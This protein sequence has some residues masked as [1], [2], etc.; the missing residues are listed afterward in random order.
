MKKCILILIILTF[1]FTSNLGIIHGKDKTQLDLKAEK[2]VLIDEYSI[3]EF[4][5]LLEQCKSTS[6]ARGG[7]DNTI[8]KINE[9]DKNALKFQKL[10]N[11][12]LK[13]VGFNSTQIN[14]IRNYNFTNETRSRVASDINVKVYTSGHLYIPEKNQTELGLSVK[15][16][17]S[18][19]Q[20]IENNDSILMGVVGT[21]RRYFRS[22]YSQ[23]GRFLYVNSDGSG[24]E[25]DK[26][27]EDIK[28][29]GEGV[30]EVKFPT[31]IFINYDD[32]TGKSNFRYLYE[33]QLHSYFITSG[34]ADISEATI[35][36]GRTSLGLSPTFSVGGTGFSL[37]INPNIYT[38]EL[39]KK[40]YTILLSKDYASDLKPTD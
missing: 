13:K 16:S 34:K 1:G 12:E 33:A 35:V 17:W 30:N 18:S 26:E 40:H 24:Y 14:A 15:F 11:D 31:T 39:F 4:Q 36:Y 19:P 8:T 2:D 7:F 23:T 27:G 32:V 20:M 38:K 28:Y 37:S 25:V 3:N 22:S 9:F 29:Y 10:S 5:F 21:D 6:I